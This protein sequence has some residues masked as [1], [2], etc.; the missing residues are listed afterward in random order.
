MKNGQI[1]EGIAELGVAVHSVSDT[2]YLC[3]SQSK[4]MAELLE[5]SAVFLHPHN[6]HVAIKENYPENSAEIYE[7]LYHLTE[8]IKA[9]DMFEA[10]HEAS[11]VI[12]DLVGPVEKHEAANF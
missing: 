8:D 2:Y 6:V 5:W 4:A 1:I 9:E 11:Y 3:R 12:Q 7:T 10:G